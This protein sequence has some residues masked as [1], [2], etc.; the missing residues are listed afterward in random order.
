MMGGC[1]MKEKATRDKSKRLALA[2]VLTSRRRNLL[3]AK[4][5]RMTP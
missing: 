2:T 4:V 1:L 3:R 5:R